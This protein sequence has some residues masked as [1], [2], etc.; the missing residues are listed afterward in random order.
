[1]GTYLP[2]A[3]SYTVVVLSP[4]P[5]ESD[6]WVWSEAGNH[7]R[8]RLLDLW[9]G[10][11]K[12]PE[13]FQGRHVVEVAEQLGGGML[14][15]LTQESADPDPGALTPR[16]HLFDPATG[17]VR[18]LGAAAVSAGS[19]TWWEGRTGGMWHTSR[20]H[21]PASPAGTLFWMSR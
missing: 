15:V 20:R 2:L 17:E 9:S 5:C 21:R 19:L 6:P 18:E 11:V 3:D 7:G 8:L 16:L 10:A 1:V 12:T 14:A 13:V 4:D